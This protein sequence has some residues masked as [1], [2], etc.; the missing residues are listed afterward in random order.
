MSRIHLAARFLLALLAART[1]TVDAADVS[2]VAPRLEVS[3][4]TLGV[5]DGASP[6]AMGLEYRWHGFSRW[7]IVPGAGL[8]AGDD[9]SRY[10]YGNLNRDFQ[11]GHAWTATISFGAGYFRDGGEVELG[12][13]LIFQSG[14]ELGRWIE[15]RWRIGLAFDHLSNGGLAGHN[16]GTEMLV[17]R[18]SMPLGGP[19]TQ[20]SVGAAAADSETEPV[21]ASWR[22]SSRRISSPASAR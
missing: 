8:V 6:L 2:R 3:A 21:A 16:P 14:I 17:L 19:W 15:R 20:P 7:T 12:H 9:D 10:V 22:S 18:V 4:G 11:I 1:V 13:P 5:L